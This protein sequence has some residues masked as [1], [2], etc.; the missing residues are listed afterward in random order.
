M[1]NLNIAFLGPEDL[2]KELGKK[3]TSTDISFYNLKKGDNT[4]TVI[5]P[6]RFLKKYFLFYTVSLADLAILVIDALKRK[7]G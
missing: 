4:L 7:A 6:S 3:G 5:E 2:V 1:P